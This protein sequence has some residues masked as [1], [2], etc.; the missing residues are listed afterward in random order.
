MMSVLRSSCHEV[1]SQLKANGQHRAAEEPQAVLVAEDHRPCAVEEQLLL[2]EGP[3][4]HVGVEVSDV[5]RLCVA[6]VP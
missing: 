4:H 1:S 2:R 3:E 5:P 6:V